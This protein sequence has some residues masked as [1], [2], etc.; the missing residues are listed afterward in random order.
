MSRI[1]S[2]FYFLQLYILFIFLYNDYFRRSEAVYQYF[3][4]K[5]TLFK[6]LFNP[7]RKFFKN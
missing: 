2:S 6:N 3:D 4:P 1:L 7:I 5:Q